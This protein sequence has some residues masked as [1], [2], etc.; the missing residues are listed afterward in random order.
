MKVLWG[1]TGA[2]ELLPRQNPNEIPQSIPAWTG[3][4]RPNCPLVRMLSFV[5]ILTKKWE[6]ARLYFP[7]RRKTTE[8][9]SY[10]PLSLE[11]LLYSSLDHLED[12]H[13]PNVSKYKHLADNESTQGSEG[14]KNKE[15]RASESTPTAEIGR[16]MSLLVL[17]ESGTDKLQELQWCTE[18]RTHKSK[19]RGGSRS[20][21]LLQNS[22]G[23]NSRHSVVSC[24]SE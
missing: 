3:S 10:F 21:A 6:W 13:I 7:F 8:E 12:T 14:E 16:E 15:R 18:R 2:E 19:N 22:C 24:S 11:T 4:I 5:S 9:R 23:I 17:A 20:Q 1:C